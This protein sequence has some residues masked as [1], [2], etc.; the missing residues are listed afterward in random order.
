MTLFLTAEEK[1]KRRTVTSIAPVNAASSMATKPLIVNIV[2]MMLPPKKSITSAT[3]S[4][5]PPVMPKMPGPAKGLRKAVCSSR[6]HTAKEEPVSNA[7]KACGSRDSMM[8]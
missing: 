1:K 2:V 8:I 7:V 5:A 6:P 3:P 4:P